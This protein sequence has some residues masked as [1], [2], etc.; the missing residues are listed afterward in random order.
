MLENYDLLLERPLAICGEVAVPVVH[1]L[2]ARPG[3]RLEDVRRVYSHPQALA[4][5]EGFLRGLGVEAVAVYDTAGGARAL[6]EG[7]D[8]A[9]AAIA[10]ER[11][12]A[13]YGLEVLARGIQDAPDNTTRFYVLGPPGATTSPP[14]P[15][16]PHR[17]VVA[18]ALPDDESPGALFW[19]LATLAYWRVNL[20]K[21]ES[22]P[23][24]RRAWHYLFY[25]DLAAHAAEPACAQALAEL[26][27][28][29]SF[30][31]ILGSFPRSEEPEP[32]AG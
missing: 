29:T 13:L 28:R 24:R 32:G 7:T 31:R 30:L 10:S 20:L 18:L 3:T 22:R 27:V 8:G 11:A 6:A 2:L 4:Q 21:I 19:C 17:T 14:A 1:C 12:A 9:A 25:L 16:R 15:D 23:S 5:C 26:R